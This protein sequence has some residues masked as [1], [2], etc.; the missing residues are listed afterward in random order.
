MDKS[1][2]DAYYTLNQGKRIKVFLQNH[3][4]VV[5]VLMSF[6]DEGMIVRGSRGDVMVSRSSVEGI[7]PDLKVSRARQVV[8]Q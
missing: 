4:V 6:D 5:G 1:K 8:Q 3:K 7:A 2:V